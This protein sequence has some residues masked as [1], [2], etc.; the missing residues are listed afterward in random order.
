M[1][2]LKSVHDLYVE[3]IK[4]IYHAEVLLIPELQLFIEKS[5]TPQLKKT[6]SN[7]LANTRIHAEQLEEIQEAI[8]ADILQE[9][10][11]TMKSM[12]METKE[13]VDRC[14]GAQLTQ[15]A[16]TA[17]LHRITHCMTTIYQMLVSM[18]DE[19]SLSTQKQILEKHLAD[20]VQFDKQISAYG[21]NILIEDI[22]L[23]QKLS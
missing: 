9:H 12:I 3:F 11:R 22:N 4:D 7:H 21:F 19:L 10:C 2:T 16:I 18:A 5:N 6:L 15:R 20:V 23:E 14:R 8:G 13:L 1:K 17:A